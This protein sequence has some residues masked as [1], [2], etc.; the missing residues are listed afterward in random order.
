MQGRQ[1]LNLRWEGS[2]GSSVMNGYH[3]AKSHS[4][5]VSIPRVV[6]SA[7]CCTCEVVRLK[8][9]LMFLFGLIPRSCEYSVTRLAWF[10]RDSLAT[11]PKA[12]WYGT[13][14]R[15]PPTS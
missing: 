2:L 5:G 12:D 7:S 6:E 4:G 3:A 10:S 8:S 9:R 11:Q 14:R 15:L 13:S 1:Y